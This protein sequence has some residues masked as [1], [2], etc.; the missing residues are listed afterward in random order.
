MESLGL[1]QPSSHYNGCIIKNNLRNL[2]TCSDDW[3]KS[4][5]AKET[6]GK[7][8]TD[9]VL[10][11]TFWADAIYTLNDTGPSLQVPRLADDGKTCNGLYI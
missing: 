2:F 6:K 5:E 4:K 9:T 11:P 8:E 7:R 1:A 3:L 10:M